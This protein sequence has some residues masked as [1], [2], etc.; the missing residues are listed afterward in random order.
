MEAYLGCK[1]ILA[2]PM[3]N[4][5]FEEKFKGGKPVNGQIEYAGYHVRYPNPDGSFYDSWSP[6]DVFERAYRKVSDDEAALITSTRREHASEE[7]D[8]E[9][10]DGK[11]NG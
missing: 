9:A 3:G 2:E 8:H 11:G 5:T 1:V 4:G 7:K 10:E 6:K